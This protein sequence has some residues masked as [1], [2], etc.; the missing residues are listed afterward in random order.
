MNVDYDTVHITIRFE[1][2]SDDPILMRFGESLSTP[3]CVQLHDRA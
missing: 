2:G 3:V 1:N